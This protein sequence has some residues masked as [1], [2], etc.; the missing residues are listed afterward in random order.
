MLR[1]IQRRAARSSGSASMM[2]VLAILASAGVSSAIAQDAPDSKRLI[3]GFY[4]SDPLLPEKPPR[5]T[6]GPDGVD[7]FVD[8]ISSLKP[9]GMIEIVLGQPR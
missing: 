3:G 2:L 1:K 9:D 8:T 4:N 7:N 6:Q 5:P